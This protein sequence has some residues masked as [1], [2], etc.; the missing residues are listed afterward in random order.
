MLEAAY[1]ITISLVCVF[2]AGA[3]LGW[4]LQEC[5]NTREKIRET[6]KELCSWNVHN[7]PNCRC[8]ISLK[9][10]DLGDDDEQL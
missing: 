10:E 8:S 3:M 5:L 9:D 2:V 6:E 1:E 7:H 4:F